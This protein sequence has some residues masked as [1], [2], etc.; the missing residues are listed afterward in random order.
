MKREMTNELFCI[1]NAPE[2]KKPRKSGDTSRSTFY[3]WM[4]LF[5]KAYTTKYFINISDNFRSDYI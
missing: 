5:S 4:L 3:D 1:L 2:E